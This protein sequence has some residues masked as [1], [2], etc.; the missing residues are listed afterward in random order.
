M[1]R[2]DKETITSEI[3]REVISARLNVPKSSL[4]VDIKTGLIGMDSYLAEKFPG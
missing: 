2:S 1:N 4:N 3:L